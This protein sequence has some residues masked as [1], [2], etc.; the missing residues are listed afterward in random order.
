MKSYSICVSLMSLSIIFYRSINII[1]SDK[2][3]FFI[4]EQYFIIYVYRYVN[5]YIEMT[6]PSIDGH[7]GCFL[8]LTRKFWCTS[9]SQLH[10]NSAAEVVEKPRLLILCGM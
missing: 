1:T 8:F 2:I 10:K 5:I 4:A 6:S 3:S 7:L 9:D